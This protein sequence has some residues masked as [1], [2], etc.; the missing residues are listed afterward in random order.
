MSN[1]AV[2]NLLT[3]RGKDKLTVRV[4]AVWEDSLVTTPIN[5]ARVVIESYDKNPS[6]IGEE[7][8]VF[9]ASLD[10]W[11]LVLEKPDWRI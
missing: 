3:I 11:D 8:I 2:N 7:Y 10:G 5:K 4:L 6:R 1:V 9:E